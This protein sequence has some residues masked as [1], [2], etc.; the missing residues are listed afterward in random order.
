MTKLLIHG[1]NFEIQGSKIFL[2]TEMKNTIIWIKLHRHLENM[3]VYVRVRTYS[4][5]SFLDMEI[6]A[7]YL[8]NYLF[9]NIYAVLI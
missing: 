3:K 2:N 7:D 8:Q 1:P 5:V 6:R 4:K 9:K